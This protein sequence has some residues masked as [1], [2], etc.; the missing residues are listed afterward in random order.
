MSSIKPVQ[1][2]Y[3]ALIGEGIQDASREMRLEA[4]VRHTSEATLNA[5]LIRQ[6]VALPAIIS[7]LGLVYDSELAAFLGISLQATADQIME[8]LAAIE[9]GKFSSTKTSATMLELFRSSSAGSSA[10]HLSISRLD[11]TF[12]YTDRLKAE[13][14]TLSR[15]GVASVD[16]FDTTLQPRS[17]DS[18]FQSF[19]IVEI[20]TIDC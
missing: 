12:R 9:E 15:L 10:A 6:H 14:H 3:V 7:T 2:E 11:E 17:D 18:F 8:T 19:K 13:L 20:S 5:H 16:L 1:K 4:L